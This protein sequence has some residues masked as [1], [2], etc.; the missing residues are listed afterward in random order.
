ME[1]FEEIRRGHAAGETIQD[2][3]GDGGVSDLLVPA[4]HGQLRG[5]AEFDTLIWPTLIF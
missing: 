5:Q 4:G 1:L 3:V 2:A